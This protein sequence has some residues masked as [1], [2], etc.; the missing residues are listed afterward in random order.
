[1]IA[2]KAKFDGK[3]IILP[4]DFER[5]EAGDVVVLFDADDWR[6]DDPA[7]LKAAEEALAKVWDN[8]DDD[9]FNTMLGMRRGC[10]SPH[11]RN[12]LS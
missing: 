8:S 2:V 4:E 10:P 9:I 3:Q 6:T 5:P 1:V 11:G 12:L 7:Y